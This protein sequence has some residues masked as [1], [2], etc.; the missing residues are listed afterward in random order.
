MDKDACC[1]ELSALLG[2]YM[3]GREL[4]PTSYTLTFMYIMTHELSALLGTFMA[5]RELTPT[6]Y[7]LTFMYIMTHTREITGKKIKEG[8]ERLRRMP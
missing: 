6:S 2:T 7:T 1:H 5:G 8:G 4:T 3:A